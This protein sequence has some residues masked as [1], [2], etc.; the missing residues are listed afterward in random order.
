VQSLE[1]QQNT[2]PL[3]LERPNTGLG[4]GR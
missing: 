2:N 3:N 1:Q 4:L